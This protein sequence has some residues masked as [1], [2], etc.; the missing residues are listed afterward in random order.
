MRVQ[1]QEPRPPP[2]LRNHLLKESSRLMRS[3]AVLGGGLA[4]LHLRLCSACLTSM[5]LA[6]PGPSGSPSMWT[7]GVEV[8]R[9]LCRDCP[10]PPGMGKWNAEGGNSSAGLQTQVTQA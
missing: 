8:E 7:F 3:G 6:A 2:S 1:H 4:L 10:S 9:S 5:R